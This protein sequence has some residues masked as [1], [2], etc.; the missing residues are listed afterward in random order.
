[1]CCSAYGDEAGRVSRGSVNAEMCAQSLYQRYN[2]VRDSPIAP[3]ALAT[4][5]FTFIL[6]SVHPLMVVQ[7][8]RAWTSLLRAYSWT[9]PTRLS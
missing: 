5:L 3:S 4:G 9:L 7:T 8:I 6:F 2:E 1:M